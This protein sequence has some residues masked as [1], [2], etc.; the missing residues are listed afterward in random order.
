MPSWATQYGHRVG[1]QAVQEFEGIDPEVGQG[2]IVDA[3]A[4]AQPAEGVVVGAEV[5]QGA[6]AADTLQGGVQP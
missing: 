2:V 3:D 5:V 1:E 4:A 6:G